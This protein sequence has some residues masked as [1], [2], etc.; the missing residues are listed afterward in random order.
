MIYKAFQGIET[1]FLGMGNM[2]LPVQKDQPGTPID[3]AKAQ[4]MIDYAMASGINYYDTA[5]VYHGG[6]SEKFLGEAFLKYPRESYYLATKFFYMADPDYKAVFREQLSRLKTDYIDF[7]LI[8]GIFEN[9]VEKYID[10]GCIEYFSKL[11]EEG[12][13]KYLGFSS[14]AGIEKFKAF[15]ER[16][17]WDFAQIQLNYYD[18]FYGQAK[19]EYEILHDLN[20]PIIA[21]EPVRGGRLAALSA[22]TEKMLK[23]ARPEWSVASWALRW[24][25]KLPGVQVVLSGMST[26]EQLRENAALFTD[27]VSLSDDEEKILQKACNTFRSEVQVPCT[28]CRYCCNDC[29][30]EINIPEILKIYNN[31]KIDG[32]W[33]LNGIKDAD[34]KGKPADCTECGSCNEHCPQSIDVKSIMKELA[35]KQ[36]K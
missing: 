2:R 1:S 3:R 32:G 4:E 28:E 8:H 25:S 16:R 23:Q 21:M 36:K 24:V 18:W 26:M 27:S 30:A 12:K 17:Q 6:E 9:T 33:A 15:T 14:H 34:S 19:Q 13:I 10:C 20:I 22:E 7:Y 5:F 29:P 11:K 35:E 31:Y